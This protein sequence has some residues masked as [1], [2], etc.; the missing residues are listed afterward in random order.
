MYDRTAGEA[1]GAAGRPCHCNLKNRIGAAR[2]G[3]SKQVYQL[4]NYNTVL[5]QASVTCG[6]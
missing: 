5:L 4:K 2:Y 6:R 1:E 3:H